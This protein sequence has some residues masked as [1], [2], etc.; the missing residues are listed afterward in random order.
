LRLSSFFDGFSGDWIIAM[1]LRRCT[2]V[3]TRR[4]VDDSSRCAVALAAIVWVLGI[5]FTSRLVAQT[6]RYSD[7]SDYKA[8]LD[9]LHHDPAHPSRLGAGTLLVTAQP[10]AELKT[11]ETASILT[12]D[13][14]LW[15][16]EVTKKYWSMRLTNKETNLT[17]QLG[18]SK[19]HLAGIAWGQGTDHSAA[20][21]LAAIQH[22][23]RHGD[24][25]HLEVG[26]S[27]S[28]AV[29]VL[30]ITVISP[31]VIRL[32]I[33]PPHLEGLGDM[34]LNVSGAGPF[35]GLGERFDQVK[36]DGLKTVLHPEDH[37]GRC[38]FFLHRAGS[39]F[40]WTRRLSAPSI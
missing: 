27:G 23:E 21:T 15:R 28:T 9:E 17:W 18:D 7:S 14:S 22:S 11:R 5:S 36:L 39:A 10:Q 12:W 33:S 37:L 20:I 31:S 35:F 30:E 6:Q 16:L 24:S 25:W 29:A 4:I 8:M 34:T 2:E 19:Q 40:I 26:V 13:T 3:T 1:T 32:R 38:L